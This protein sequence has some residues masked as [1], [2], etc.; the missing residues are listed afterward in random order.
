MALEKYI[1]VHRLH[2][3]KMTMETHTSGCVDESDSR[4]FY[5]KMEDPS[6]LGTINGME[7]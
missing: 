5:L 1:L 7:G 4:K 6:L 2:I 3:I